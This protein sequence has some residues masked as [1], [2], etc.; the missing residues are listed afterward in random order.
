MVILIG[1]VRNISPK[2]NLDRLLKML[3]AVKPRREALSSKCQFAKNIQSSLGRW[4]LIWS[5][6]KPLW[7][8][9]SLAWTW[10]TFWQFHCLRAPLSPHL[11]NTFLVSLNSALGPLRFM[12]PPPPTRVIYC[13]WGL[14]WLPS[15][16][17]NQWGGWSLLWTFCLWENPPK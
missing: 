5:L 12:V 14:W 17:R 7:I 10:M 16:G 9:W 11:Y 13:L 6:R 1:E 4:G 15:Q 3:S 8:R 2:N